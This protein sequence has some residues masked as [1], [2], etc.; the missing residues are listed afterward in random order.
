M[1]RHRNYTVSTETL[2]FLLHVRLGAKAWFFCR[3]STLNVGALTGLQDKRYS[4]PIVLILTCR[5]RSAWSIN[6]LSVCSVTCHL[7]SL[8]MWHRRPRGGKGEAGACRLRRLCF[9][10][11]L[12]GACASNYRQKRGGPVQHV[13]P[14]RA[15][16]TM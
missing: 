7:A 13:V 9:T 14:F 3:L 15:G 16:E 4:C 12:A 8:R 11:C 10:R 5:S 6:V 1:S 2:V